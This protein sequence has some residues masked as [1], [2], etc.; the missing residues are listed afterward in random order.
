MPRSL[1]LSLSRA[2]YQPFLFH[3]MERMSMSRVARACAAT[4]CASSCRSA[5]VH[6][7]ERSSRART[8]T[9][10]AIVSAHPS[11]SH[12]THSRRNSWKMRGR[13][14]ALKL[15][16]R[17]T[18]AGTSQLLEFQRNRRRVDFAGSRHGEGGEE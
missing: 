5:H 18:E 12:A 17:F 13:W 14:M 3:S 6:V 8:R 2:I 15:G 9:S 7:H 4:V 10:H 11:P 1:S 16:T